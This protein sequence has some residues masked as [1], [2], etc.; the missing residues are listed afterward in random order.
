MTTNIDC[1]I[2]TFRA[3]EPTLYRYDSERILGLLYLMFVFCC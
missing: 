1:D 3:Q 2:W